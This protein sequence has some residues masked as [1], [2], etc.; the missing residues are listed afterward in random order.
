MSR[1]DVWKSCYTCR[2]Y[3]LHRR[4]LLAGPLADKAQREGRDV[5]EVVDDFMLAAHDRHQAGEPLRPGGPTRT[6][7]PNLART[8]ALLAQIKHWKTDV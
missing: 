1:A 2:D 4:E 7:D 3:A 5:V 8:A 6:T